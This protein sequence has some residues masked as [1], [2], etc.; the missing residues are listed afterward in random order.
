VSLEYDGKVYSDNFSLPGL[1]KLIKE[2]KDKSSRA[3]IVQAAML[4]AVMPSKPKEEN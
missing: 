2:N 3:Y 4:E 1:K